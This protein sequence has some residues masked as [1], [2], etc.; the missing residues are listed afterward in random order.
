MQTEIEGREKLF[1]SNRDFKGQV[2][3]NYTSR[4]RLQ[5]KDYYKRQEG[6][7]IM[8]NKS[9]QEEERSTV[10]IYA[11]NIEPPKYIKKT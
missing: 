9:F 4:N 10:N 2:I 7:Y 3:N 6:H 5:N 11:P 8:I 1:N